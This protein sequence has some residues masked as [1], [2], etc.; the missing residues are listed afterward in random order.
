MQPPVASL[1]GACTLCPNINELTT[2]DGMNPLIKAGRFHHHRS[3]PLGY[4]HQ[5][6]TSSVDAK[7]TKIYHRTRLVRLLGF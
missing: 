2:V 3:L 5:S 6:W 4:A 7:C 1:S